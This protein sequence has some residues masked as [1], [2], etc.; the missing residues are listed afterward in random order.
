MGSPVTSDI[1]RERPWLARYDVGQP[2]DITPEF[3]DGLAMFRATVERAP[4]ADAIRYFDGRITYGE[5]DALTD[6]FAAGLLDP[7]VVEGGLAAGDRVALYLQNVP[8]FVI[9]L[10]GIWKAGGIPVSV[11][12]MNRERELDLLLRDSGARVLVCLQGLYRDVAASVVGGTE[13]VTV[14]TTSE[15]E[16]QTRDDPRVFDGVERLDPAGSILADTV[17]MAA[18]LTRFRGQTPP[19]VSFS[20]DDT[21][22]M[23][24]TSGTTGPPKGAMNTHANVVFNSQAYRQWCRLSGDDVVLGVAPLFHITGLI[25][26]VTISLL[27]GV[28]LVLFH[29]FDAAMAI[30]TIRAERPPSPSGR[31]RCSSR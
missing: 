24:Y 9:G 18:L 15:L 4:D 21:A 6:A 5:L 31:S 10:V 28:P 25:A 14:I 16:Y 26:H 17:D 11:N 29:R 13:V 3:T 20:V 2:H 27:L 30:E 12:P 8:Q 7:S 19:P 22:L 1:Y 23:T